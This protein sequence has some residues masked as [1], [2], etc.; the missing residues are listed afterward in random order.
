M[1]VENAPRIVYKNGTI[2]KKL[3]VKIT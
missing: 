3:R 1:D 2:S